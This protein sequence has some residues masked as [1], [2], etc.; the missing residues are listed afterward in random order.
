MRPYSP[1]GALNALAPPRKGSNPPTASAHRLLPGLPGYLIPFAPL[2]FVSSAS[3]CVQS[4]AF[5]TDVPPDI[6]AFHCYT[7]N[8][9][10]PSTPLARQFSTAFLGWAQGFHTRLSKPPT[11]ALRPIIPNN[12]C[13]LRITA[14]AGTELAGTSFE[15]TVSSRAYLTRLFSSLLTEVYDPKAFILHAASLDQTF[16]HCP[17]FLTAASRRSQGRISV[18]MWQIIR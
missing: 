3:E 9:R 18:P 1:G 15:G 5:A 6:Y 8:S 16:V 2:A 4:L 7:G 10:L 12:A 14:A 17:I 13:A 11:P